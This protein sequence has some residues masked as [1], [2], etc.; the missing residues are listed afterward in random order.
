MPGR[1]PVHDRHLRVLAGPARDQV[2]HRRVHRRRRLPQRH[3]LCRPPRRRQQGLLLR[4]GH[5]PTRSRR[6]RLRHRWRLR[7]A[8]VRRQPVHDDLRPGFRSPVPGRLRLREPLRRVPLLRRRHRRRR[9]RD[10][11]GRGWGRRRGVAAAAARGAGDPAPE[12]R[13]RQRRR[14]RRRATA[15]ATATIRQG[16]QRVARADAATTSERR[17]CLR[18][19]RVG[20]L[21]HLGPG[22]SGC[23]RRR[24][25]TR[26]GRARWAPWRSRCRRRWRR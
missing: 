9:L 25:C 7:L 17:W 21:R 15:T 18:N 14:R 8:A 24:T 16:T 26:S 12:D 3:D 5:R 4:R 20:R 11:R 22:P 13:Q 1:H 6:R 23:R 2:L 10:R 19:R